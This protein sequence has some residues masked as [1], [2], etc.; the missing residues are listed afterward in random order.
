MKK[1]MKKRILVHIKRKIVKTAVNVKNPTKVYSAPSYIQEQIDKRV[2]SFFFDYQKKT[3]PHTSLWSTESMACFGTI[4]K[5][6]I[7]TLH[8]IG[9][10]GQRLPQGQKVKCQIV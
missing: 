10:R 7:I 1:R 5:G 9:L 8:H 2:S 6:Y 4:E 3:K